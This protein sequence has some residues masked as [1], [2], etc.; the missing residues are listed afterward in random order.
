MKY[1]IS[2]VFCLG[3]FTVKS[4]VFDTDSTEMVNDTASVKKDTVRHNLFES[5]T[6]SYGQK[7]ASSNFDS[8]LKTMS[9]GK[10]SMPCNYFSI[11]MIG[12]I[13][14]NRRRSYTG[15]VNF[16]YLVPTMITIN[17]SVKEKLN[18]FTYTFSV[19]GQKIVKKKHFEMFL[20]EGISMGR[21]KMTNGNNQKL[22]NPSFAP[23]AG[24]VMRVSFSKFSLFSIAQFDYDISKSSWHRMNKGSSQ[25]ITVSPLHQGGYT[26]SFGINYSISERY[27]KQ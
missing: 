27:M 24:L 1:W 18:G 22:K 19:F 11:G 13:I 10:F 15:I 2:F 3:L 7:Y 14:V 12:E 26:F 6:F 21:L 25:N 8:Q 4:Q 20:T 17:D 5:L 9:G 16:S 23:F